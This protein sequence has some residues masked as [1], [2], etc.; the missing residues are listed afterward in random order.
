MNW[1]HLLLYK[2]YLM[3]VNFYINTISKI[4]LWH[5]FKLMKLLFPQVWVWRHGHLCWCWQQFARLPGESVTVS[6]RHFDE[7]FLRTIL[8]LALLIRRALIRKPWATWLSPSRRQL[9]FN[10]LCLI[11]DLVFEIEFYLMSLTNSNTNSWNSIV[12]HTS[13]PFCVSTLLVFTF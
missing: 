4:F 13:G 6:L 11:F 7:N 9:C 2:N 12:R 10:F 3:F 8:T 1:H 5:F